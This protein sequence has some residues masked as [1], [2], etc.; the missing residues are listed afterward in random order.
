MQ[1]LYLRLAWVGEYKATFQ[2]WTEVQPGQNPLCYSNQAI[3]RQAPRMESYPAGE[4]G[5][6]PSGVSITDT[7]KPTTVE[8]PKKNG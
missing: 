6:K 7:L 2:S 5:K 4:P 8:V 3:C 1:S